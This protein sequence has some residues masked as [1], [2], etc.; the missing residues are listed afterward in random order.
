[1]FV[2]RRTPRNHENRPKVDG[3]SAGVS[4]AVAGASR[5]RARAEPVL[6]GAKEC[7]RH[8]G[9]DARTT[10]FKAVSIHECGPAKR[11]LSRIFCLTRPLIYGSL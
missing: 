5:S 7:P 6:S 8:S 4:P 9:R 2:S 3:C 11:N 1:M 10:I